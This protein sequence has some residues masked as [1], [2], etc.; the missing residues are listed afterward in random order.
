MH[1][2]YYLRYSTRK[3]D[4]FKLQF[5]SGTTQFLALF[6]TLLDGINLYV[7]ADNHNYFLGLKVRTVLTTMSY[8]LYPSHA[9]SFVTFH[10][11]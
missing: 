11:V 8:F 2:L 10:L 9:N 6:S 7:G 4:F 3:P 1:S 5:A